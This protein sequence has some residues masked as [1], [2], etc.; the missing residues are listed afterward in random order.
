MR[1]RM[2][3]L[4]QT[5]MER[6]RQ[7]VEAARRRYPP[8]VLADARV[9]DEFRIHA[10]RMARLRRAELVAKTELDEP[11]R[12]EVLA[13]VKR[14]MEREDARHDKRIARLRSG[15]GPGGSAAPHPTPSASAA[16]HPTP[17]ASAP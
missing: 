6:R 11:K 1:A 8:E 13:R 14:L 3:E 9:R 16:L 2:E 7:H 10:R 12:G 17:K 5:R 4:R 15:P